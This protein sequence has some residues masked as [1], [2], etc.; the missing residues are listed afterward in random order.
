MFR[1]RFLPVIYLEQTRAAILNFLKS[2]QNN[3]YICSLLDKIIITL[4]GLLS[5]LFVARHVGPETL[6]NWF[7]IFTFISLFSLIS[8]F[9]ATSYLVRIGTP[10]SGQVT[11][12]IFL[13]C[14]LA[15][16]FI[17]LIITS[18]NAFQNILPSVFSGG[19]IHWAT[20]LIFLAALG[21]HIKA[22]IIV[23]NLYIKQLFINLFS[24]GMSLL[25]FLNLSEIN[26]YSLLIFN[27]SH[28]L[29]FIIICLMTKNWSYGAFGWSEIKQNIDYSKFISASQ[30]SESTSRFIVNLIFYNFIGAGFVG[31]FNHANRIL[32]LPV[33]NS[34]HALQRV[35]LAKISQNSDAKE[36]LLL[37]STTY[38]YLNM[39][40]YLYFIFIFFNSEKIVDLLYGSGEEWFQMAGVLKALSFSILL[41]PASAISINFLQKNGLARRIFILEIVKRG[42]FYVVIVGTSYFFETFVAVAYSMLFLCFAFIDYSAIDDKNVKHILIDMKSFLLIVS[43]AIISH[44]GLLNFFTGY[45]YFSISVSLLT[46]AAV[47]IFKNEKS[48]R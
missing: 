46:L 4:A 30:L 18:L 13:S 11:A 15:L 17:S 3:H 45:S 44:I 2:I 1:K 23:K 36:T 39:I 47:L 37:Y 32:S 20:F 6:G 41:L 43:C 24:I 31:M 33:R 12:S 28:Q 29:I 10:N 42:I 48:L 26:I 7:L 8:E 14:S 19:I 5:S 22:L 34:I 21:A 35:N 16:L 38:K 27:I 40:S 25:I 9:G